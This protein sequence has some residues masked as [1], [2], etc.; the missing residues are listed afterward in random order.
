VNALIAAFAAAAGLGGLLLVAVALRPVP[1]KPA[2]GVP[3]SPLA[4]RLRRLQAATVGAAGSE[5]PGVR[6]RQLVLLL[7][8]AG[9]LLAWLVTGLALM[10]LAVP[11]AVVGLPRLLGT[12]PSAARI[13][14]LEALEEWTRNLAGVL[15]VGVGLE[16][17][18]TASLRSTPTAIGPQVATLVARLSARWNTDAALRAFADDLDD[19]TGDLVAA[20]LILSARR[21]GA[22]LVAVLEGL[23][24]SVADDVRTRR[25]IEADRAKPRSTARA[26]TFITLGVLVLLALNKTYVQ[27]YTSASGQALLAVLLSAYVGALVWM[28]QMTIGRPTARFLTNCVASAAADDLLTPATRDDR[29]TPL[30]APQPRDSD[31]STRKTSR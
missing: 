19:A 21:R 30:S 15:A 18:I 23:A 3:S 7:A 5:A 4:L 25:A 13:D 12:P 8:L 29:P 9:G 2:A 22:G 17:A 11:V 28:R 27:P 1:A 14:R 6:R 31:A 20:S 24:A 16:Q 26:V 10:V